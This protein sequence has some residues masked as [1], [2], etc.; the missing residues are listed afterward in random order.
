MFRVI[1][2]AAALLLSACDEETK[3]VDWWRN[4]PDEAI[5]QSQECKTSGSDSDNCKN[6]KVAL[7]RNQQQD[8][9]IPTFE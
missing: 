8:A 4:H 1:I 6:A 9:P 7:H 5:K 2:V 3:S